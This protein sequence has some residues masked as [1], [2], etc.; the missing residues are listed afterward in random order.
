MANSLETQNLFEVTDAMP[1]LGVMGTPPAVA[2]QEGSSKKVTRSALQES[3]LVQEILMEQLTTK[4][5]DSTTL[6]TN[7]FLDLL[8][9]STT[10]PAGEPVEE[11]IWTE[12][13]TDNQLAAKV[14]VNDPYF[15]DHEMLSL[16]MGD[17]QRRFPK[18]FKFLN[19]LCHH[20][21]FLAA[22]QRVWDRLVQGSSMTKVW[23]ELKLMKT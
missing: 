21:E 18:P 1:R 22:V 3:H 15:S 9:A 13:F 12:F 23:Q 11:K 16:H 4:E 7:R 10:D 14:T 8:H 19:H 2:I 17:K 5:Q 6:G 20:K